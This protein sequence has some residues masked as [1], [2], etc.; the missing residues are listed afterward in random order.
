MK[1]NIVFYGALLVVL[2]GIGFSLVFGI[3]YMFGLAMEMTAETNRMEQVCLEQGYPE[4]TISGSNWYCIRQLNGTD[5]VIPL[6]DLL[7]E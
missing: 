4:A 3:F 5:E 2:L 1:A 6:S 7:G